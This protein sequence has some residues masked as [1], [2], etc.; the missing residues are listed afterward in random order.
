MYRCS[1]CNK[2]F[3]KIDARACQAWVIFGNKS[4][5]H[6]LLCSSPQKQVPC[7]LSKIGS[8]YRT[9]V[10]GLESEVS[11]HFH[12][13]WSFRLL[14]TDSAFKSIKNHFGNVALNFRRSCCKLIH[15][16]EPF[17]KQENLDATGCKRK[18][19]LKRNLLRSSFNFCK[20]ND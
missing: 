9:T 11:R 20:A 10:N 14:W 12:S 2:S 8:S 17:H 18:T 19:F 3:S 5:K 6:F 4:Q 16:D 13:I 15:V 1:L 7:Y